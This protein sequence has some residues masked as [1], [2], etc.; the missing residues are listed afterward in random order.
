MD[1]RNIPNPIATTETNWPILTSPN[2]L[3]GDGKGQ[4]QEEEEEKETLN[5]ERREEQQ[6]SDIVT[7]SQYRARKNGLQNVINTTQAGLGRL[8]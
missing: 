1:I 4:I 3:S 5:F 6:I 7:I 8:V 2:F